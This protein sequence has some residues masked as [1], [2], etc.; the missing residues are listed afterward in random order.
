[1]GITAATHYPAQMIHLVV[2][3]VSSL[4]PDVDYPKSWTGKAFFFLSPWIEKRFGHRTVTHSALG[5]GIAAVLCLPLVILAKDIYYLCLIGYASHIA[6]DMW[7]K[8]GVSFLWPLKEYTFVIPARR[9]WRVEVGSSG[10]TAVLIIFFSA[11]IVLYH[12]Q[13]VGFYRMLHL[14]TKDISYARDDFI[15]YSSTNF[16][17]LKG[18]FRDNATLEVKETEYPVVGMY[19]EGLLVRNDSHLKLVSKLDSGNLYPLSAALEIK[20]PMRAISSRINLDGKTIGELSQSVDQDIEH[21]ILGEA[22]P[23]S[24]P[25]KIPDESDAYNPLYMSGD[26]IKFHYATAKDLEPFSTLVLKQG[27][28]IVQYRVKPYEEPP[29]L[30]GHD[31]GSGIIET[32]LLI[33]V[34]DF[35]SVLV[36]VGDDIKKGDLIAYDPAVQDEIER[37]EA[38]LKALEADWTGERL[39]IQTRK[40][41]M[42][43][44]LALIP[45]DANLEKLRNIMAAL[46]IE[47]RKNE[48]NSIIGQLALLEEQMKVEEEAYNAKKKKLE[49]DIKQL[50]SKMD[51]E[52]PVSGKVASMRLINIT[53]DK[54]NMELLIISKNPFPKLVAK[55]DK[56]ASNGFHAPNIVERCKVVSVVDGDTFDCRF[57]WLRTE[58]IRLIGVDTPETKHP[59]KGIEYYGKEA[60][61]FTKKMLSGKEIGLE[62][63]VQKLD[64]YNRVLVYAYLEDGRMF[65]ALLV[66]EGYAQAAT[67]PPNV[68]YQKLLVDLQKEA[69]ENNRGLWRLQ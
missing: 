15:K 53:G 10:E 41:E 33:S 43:G 48:R 37:K 32:P 52:S 42:E 4:L 39:R 45:S 7:N 31:P 18:K 30:N 46:E 3:C 47:R 8:N 35:E 36:K 9:A 68:K 25:P 59:A 5:C 13:G 21:Y 38:E 28:A 17:T 69:R 57:G 50:R 1:M 11:S 56:S 61:N 65:N 12:F 54:A 34:R 62:Y 58:K 14:I 49:V 16:T 19:K 63:D 51:I 26:R 24:R 44:R 23:A 66:R 6:L 67:Y 27:E 40:N 2:L 20:E 29:S 60:S 55:T 22:I 64:K